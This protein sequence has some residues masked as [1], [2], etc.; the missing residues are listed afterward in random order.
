MLT[1]LYIEKRKTRN[2][3]LAHADVIT[4]IIIL[5]I[6]LIVQWPKQVNQGVVVYIACLVY[7]TTLN[8]NMNILKYSSLI[9]KHLLLPFHSRITLLLDIIL[10]LLLLFYNYITWAASIS[11]QMSRHVIFYHSRHPG[12]YIFIFSRIYWT[13]LIFSRMW[14]IQ[15]VLPLLPLVWHRLD[16]LFTVVTGVEV[17]L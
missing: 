17:Y 6:I 2:A 4:I 9:S 8:N 10:L 7:V 3:G 1:E 5:I 15:K 14:L 13:M 12:W 16:T 11:K